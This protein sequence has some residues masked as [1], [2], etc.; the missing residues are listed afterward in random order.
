[1]HVFDA[2]S[3]IHAWDNYPIEQFPPLWDWMASRILS[4]AFSIPELALREVSKKSPEC[5]SWLRDAHIEVLELDRDVLQEAMRI[6]HLLGIVEDAYHPK[7][8][9]EN[10][11]LIIA[12]ARR[13][14]AI[15]VS[16]E[17][18]QFRLPPARAR[19]KI[20]AVCELP[21]ITVP[22][23]PFVTMIKQSRA[24]FV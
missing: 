10:D 1:M 23:I 6:K 13:S 12:T 20:P 3:M 14:G 21:E 8:V 19:Y 16:E 22:C 15:L 7:G 4:G 24:V 11:I 9:G 2:S 18:K 5:A 17:A